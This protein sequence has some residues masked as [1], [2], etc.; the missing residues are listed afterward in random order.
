MAQIDEV[1][2]N[3]PVD[4]VPIDTPIDEVPIDT[5]PD[6]GEVTA[7]IVTETKVPKPRGR[8]R[9]STDSKPR[10]R[11]DRIKPNSPQKAKYRPPASP[12]SSTESPRNLPPPVTRATRKQQ[13]YDSWFA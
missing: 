13:M 4:E 3:T 7:T 10:V 6:A 1:P 12:S 11:K 8:P 9:G 2:I 5:A